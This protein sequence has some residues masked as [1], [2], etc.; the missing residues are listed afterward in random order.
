MPEIASLHIRDRGLKSARV[1]ALSG[2][3]VRVGRSPIC[4]VLL[5]DPKVARVECHLTREAGRW[6]IIPERADGRVWYQGE[7]LTGPLAIEEGQ[8]IFVGENALTLRLGELSYAEPEPEPEP[9]PERE[10]EPDPEPVPEP[11]T[12]PMPEFVEVV[13]EVVESVSTTTETE[14][15]TTNLDHRAESTSTTGKHDRL[16]QTRAETRKWESRWRAVGEKL[17][18]TSVAPAAPPQ[19]PAGT[20]VAPPLAHRRPAVTATEPPRSPVAKKV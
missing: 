20:S 10:R 18:E 2:D 5:L 8:T 6:T 12:K 15:S 7:R 19:R 16:L 13:A 17:R 9:E 11:E 14:T 1:V 4:D 3:Y